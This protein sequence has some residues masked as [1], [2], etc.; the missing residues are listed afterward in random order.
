MYA[1]VHILAGRGRVASS[2]LGRLYPGKAPVLNLQETECSPE[3]V[4][5]PRNEEKSAPL[6]HPGSNPGRPDR[7]QTLLLELLVA[8]LLP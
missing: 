5:T 8:L 1:R 3:P 7:S 6:R 2:T 4:W